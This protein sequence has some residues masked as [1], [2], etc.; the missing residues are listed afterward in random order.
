MKTPFL[1]S[2]IPFKKFLFTLLLIFLLPHSICATYD[3]NFLEDFNLE[4]T[5]VKQEPPDKDEKE[6]SL[7]L[8]K[9]MSIPWENLEEFF[10]NFSAKEQDSNAPFVA[11]LLKAEEDSSSPSF[12]AEGE[13]DFFLSSPPSPPREEQNTTTLVDPFSEEPILETARLKIKKVPLA[14]IKEKANSQI[15]S[16]LEQDADFDFPSFAVGGYVVQLKED[17][18]DQ[19]QTLHLKNTIVGIYGVGLFSDSRFGANSVP[20]SPSLTKPFYN[21]LRLF[22]EPSQVYSQENFDLEVLG[23]LVPFIHDK[24]AKKTTVFLGNR[25][26]KCM[27]QLKGICTTLSSQ[28]GNDTLLKQCSILTLSNFVYYDIH[29]DQNGGTHFFTYTKNPTLQ[30]IADDFQTSSQESKPRV[31]HE[32]EASPSSSQKKKK[33]KR[34]EKG[35]NVQ[36]L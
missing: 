31:S 21:A 35:N 26:R 36:E 9:E 33:Q 30:K 34:R 22:S 2:L 8:T 13:V 6:E 28:I 29:G 12:L 1:V 5:V 19:N 7:P 18:R 25:F 10:P 32:K 11:P 4:K 27:L 17:Y 3:D 15:P 24:H 16:Y 20:F 23:A 14:K